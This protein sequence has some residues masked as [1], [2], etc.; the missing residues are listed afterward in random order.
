MK[1]KDLRMKIR[2]A[3]ALSQ[4]VAP[5]EQRGYWKAIVRGEVPGFWEKREVTLKC[6]LTLMFHEESVD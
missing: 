6:D 4:Y 1:N 2:V 5:S 3:Q